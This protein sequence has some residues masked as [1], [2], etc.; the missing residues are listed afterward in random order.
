MV[1]ILA[2]G[3]T[4]IILTGGVD[5]SNG[6]V[7]AFGTIVMTKLA[8]NYHLNPFLA[9]ALGIAVCLAFGVLNGLLSRAFA[10]RRSSSRWGR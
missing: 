10:S 1:G 8:V 3:Q 2:I 4:L 9:I 5:L 6:S 7:M